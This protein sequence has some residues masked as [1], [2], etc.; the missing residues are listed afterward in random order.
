MKYLYYSILVPFLIYFRLLFYLKNRCIINHYLYN[1]LDY[2]NLINHFNYFFVFYLF[3][4]MCIL[5]DLC[6]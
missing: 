5:N 3:F 4:Q 2:T 6:H 1:Y